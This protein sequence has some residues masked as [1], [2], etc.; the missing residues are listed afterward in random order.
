MADVDD[1][2]KDSFRDHVATIS[3]EGKRNYIYPKKPKGKLTNMRSYVAAGLLVFF[4]VTPWLQI[5]GQ[6]FLMLNVLERKFVIFGN[7]FWPQDFH[8]LVLAMLTGVVFIILFTVVFGRLFC[9]WVCPQTIFMEHV[10]RKIEYWIDG[11]RGQQ[12][13]LSKLP[14]S[15]PEKIRK[16]LL[17]N[18]IF[19]LISFII[20]NNFLMILV[21]TGEWL[22][23]VTDGPMAH[24]GNFIGILIFT[25]VFYFIFAWFR[26]Q[27]CI[28]VCPYGRLQGV[29]LDRHSVVIAYDYKR[30]EPRGRF[31][32][33]ENRSESGKGDCI[34]CNQCVDVCPTGIDIRNGTQLE[35]INCTACIDACDAMMEKVNLPKGLIRYASEESIA[36]EKKHTY[37]TRAKAYSAVLGVLVIV[38]GFLL[39]SRPPVEATILRAQGQLYQEQPDGTIS[40][41]YN[42]KIINKSTEDQVFEIE[43]LEPK[44]SIEMVG[45][46]DHHIEIGGLSQGSFFVKVDPSTLTQSNTNIQLRVLS[47]GEEVDVIRTSFN[48]PRVRTKK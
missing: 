22:A 33:N 21:G 45:T 14:W 1:L 18:G 24:L 11:D 34:D 29:L 35:C 32:K 31:K 17:K 3:E 6:P 30:G 46:P 40:N 12:I 5:D 2:E 44:G 8:L 16:R 25:T 10:F 13:R 23:V 47:N 39:N 4:F 37:T 36:E 20:A 7:V 28:I 38:M 27:V 41:L 26:E 19:W 43:L 42:Y 48:G 9:G 15:N